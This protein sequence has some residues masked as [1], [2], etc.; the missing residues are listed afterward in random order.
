MEKRIDKIKRIIDANLN[1]AR[2]GLRV[3]EDI[4][5]FV[6]N[7]KQTT[8][9]IKNMR[10]E[11]SI[12][13]KKHKEFLNFRNT[14]LDVGVKLSNTNE[15]NRNS[16]EDIVEANIKRVEESLR[17]LEEMFKF[18]DKEAALTFKDLRYKSYT[19]EKTVI[20]HL[21]EIP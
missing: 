18:L 4:A 1:R 3:V 12:I 2:E 19:I 10:A 17:V 5:R 13:Q 9:A 16:M 11:I 21:Q 7:D 20:K 14:E 8:Q 6:L 15:N